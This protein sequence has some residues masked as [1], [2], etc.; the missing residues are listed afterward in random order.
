MTNLKPQIPAKE[1]ENEI[2]G[3]LGVS[4]GDTFNAEVSKGFLNFF[5]REVTRRKGE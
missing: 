2:N 3:L 4:A 5:E 1:V